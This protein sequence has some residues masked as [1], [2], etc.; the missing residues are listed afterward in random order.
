[1]HKI[2]E[3]LHVNIKKKYTQLLNFSG[4][5]KSVRKIHT[6]MYTQKYIAIYPAF[7]DF[8]SPSHQ[9]N[10]K[11]EYTNTTVTKSS[12]NS[13]LLADANE[14]VGSL[15]GSFVGDEDGCFVGCDRAVGTLLGSFVD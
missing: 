4:Q 12:D 11:D 15:L 13:E 14:E 6:N 9:H 7:C 5:Q 8:I 10:I 3:K 2:M 1:M